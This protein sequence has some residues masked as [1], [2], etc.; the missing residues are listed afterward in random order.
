MI[1]LLPSEYVLLKKALQIRRNTTE[2][3]GKDGRMYIP[4]NKKQTS[5]YDDKNFIYDAEVS[6]ASGH[7]KN[8]WESQRNMSHSVRPG[9]FKP[10]KDKIKKLGKKSEVYES[11]AHPSQWTSTIG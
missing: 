6:R 9:S 11:E 1:I 3:G 7:L 2:A 8:K 10:K 5:Q 4:S